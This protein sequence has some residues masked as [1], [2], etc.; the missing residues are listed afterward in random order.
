M[1]FPGQRVGDL[2]SVTMSWT[3]QMST[4]SHGEALIS[5]VLMNYNFFYILLLHLGLIGIQVTL[6][7]S[8]IMTEN[9]E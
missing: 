2:L 1:I 4:S 6:G 7:Y 8:G 9:H 3:R 5:T